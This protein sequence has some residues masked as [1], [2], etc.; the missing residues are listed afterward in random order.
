MLMKKK[1]IVAAV[2][3]AVVAVA[4]LSCR[5][6]SDASQGSRKPMPQRPDNPVHAIVLP[7]YYPS[8]PPGPGREAFAAGC[9][10]CHTTRYIGTQPPVTAVKW[11]ENVRKMMKVYGAPVTEEQ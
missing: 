4:G 7:R 11:E 1:L 3:S 5:P 6:R 8:L 10:T 2:V 9:L